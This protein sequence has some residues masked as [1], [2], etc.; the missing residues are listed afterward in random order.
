[1]LIF[2]TCR[3][4]SNPMIQ[5]ICSSLW[6]WK[7]WHSHAMSLFTGVSLLSHSWCVF[8]G[9]L[10]SFVGTLTLL[11]T[12][13]DRS[14]GS[15]RCWSEVI[16]CLV[17]QNLAL[18]RWTEIRGPN[19]LLRDLLY[20]LVYLS[21]SCV[22]LTL[23]VGCVPVVY[24]YAN[25]QYMFKK[26]ILRIPLDRFYAIKFQLNYVCMFISLHEIKLELYLIYFG[27]IHILYIWYMYLGQ[28]WNIAFWYPH[29]FK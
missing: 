17:F 22:P 19:L 23:N 27:L 7:S 16:L 4:L 3:Y 20:G 25:L 18:G 5:H 9:F 28:I 24:V 1:M 15:R 6:I 2:K 14:V 8:L 12:L 10:Q 11:G 29:Q 13:G 21:V 26:Y